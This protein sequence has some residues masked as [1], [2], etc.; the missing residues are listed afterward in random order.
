[1]AGPRGRCGFGPEVQEVGYAKDPQYLPFEG[2]N[3][4]P[5]WVMKQVR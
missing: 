4:A 1:M 5:A 3:A 2:T